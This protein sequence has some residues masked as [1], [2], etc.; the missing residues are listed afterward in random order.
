M[1]INFFQE[2]IKYN[3]PQK[4]LS[5]KWLRH[6][7]QKEGFTISDLNYI[8]CTDEYLHQINI[9]YLNHDTYTDIITFDN[10]E[11]ENKIES[12]IFISIERVKENSKTEG[13]EFQKEI[14]R[15]LSHG[16]LHLCGYKDKSKEEAL[17]MRK[18]EDESIDFFLRLAEQKQSST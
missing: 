13:Q 3:L 7:A 5:K 1:A 12:D 8:F 15:V 2:D 18:K 10:S 11:E 6:I 16:I 17:L 14:L 9:E 4:N